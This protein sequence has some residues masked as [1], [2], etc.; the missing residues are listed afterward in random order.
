MTNTNNA[1]CKWKIALL[2]DIQAPYHT[3]EYFW[4]DWRC[5]AIKC[6]YTIILLLRYW[7]F[8]IVYV[9]ERAMDTISTILGPSIIRLWP[10]LLVVLWPQIGSDFRNRAG[11]Q[12]VYGH[13]AK[14]CITLFLRYWCFTIVYVYERAIDTISTIVWPSITRLQPLVGG[15]LA[16]GWVRFSK[17]SRWSDNVWPQRKGMHHSLS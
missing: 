9:Y 3:Y 12:T 8:A 11:C 13:S 7:C 10:L 4:C 6:W 17:S 5:L 2:A 1:P 15:S 14:A 16:S